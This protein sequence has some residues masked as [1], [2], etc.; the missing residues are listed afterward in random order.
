MGLE[1]YLRQSY[2]ITTVHAHI[3]NT[4]VSDGSLW[5]SPQL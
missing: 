4:A 3:T 1:G 2:K 5:D